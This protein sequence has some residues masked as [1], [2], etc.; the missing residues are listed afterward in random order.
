LDDSRLYAW[1]RRLGVDLRPDELRTALFLL[2]YFF[3]ITF[4]FY[5]VKT[6]KES[7]QI[8]VNERWWGYFDLG[9]A[10]LIGFVVAINTRLLNR[11]P[12]RK[13]SLLTL[14]FSAGCLVLFWFL[15]GLADWRKF[16]I[17]ALLVFAKDYWYLFV[18]AFS[19]WSDIFIAMSI[20]QFWIAV[21]DVLHP[22]QARRLVGFL[23]TGGLLG[24]IGGALVSRGLSGVWPPYRLLLICPAVLA[25]TILVV[26]L[27][28]GERDRVRG[29]TEADPVR[30]GTGVGYLESLRTVRSHRYLLLISGVLA[31][32]VIVGQLINYQFKFVVKAQPWNASGRT[33]F[34]ATFF[35]GILVL[36]L[37]FHLFTTGRL[38]KR[39]GI[40]LALLVAPLVLLLGTVPIFALTAAAA[41]TAVTAAG[42]RLWA[43]GLRGA[44]RSFDI[45]INQ[46]VRELL[47]IP[48]P[49]EIKY[50]A[51]VFID[52]FVNKFALGFG[53]VIYWVLYRAA[54]F[55][56]R[57][58]DARV[59]MLGF[60]VIAFA[61]VWVGLIWV[62][63]A[64]YKEA[65]N[66][67]LARI[68]Q[69]GQKV[70][71]QHVDL[72]LTRLIMNTIES[73]ERS[74]TLYAMNLFELV[75]KEKL[76][77]ELREAIGLKEDEVKARSMDA[78]LDVG[79]ETFFQSIEEAITDQDLE[80][81]VK[82]VMALPVYQ[83]LMERRI[84]DFVGKEG[85]SEVVRM[86]SAQ[87]LGRMALTPGVV[88]SIGRLLQD[89][90]ADVLNYA[91]GSAAVH[92]R[93]EHV[94]LIIPLLGNPSTQ[95]LAQE[96]LAAYGP[97]IED[98]LKK[99]LQHAGE[100][101]EVR[102][103]IPEVLGRYGDQKAADTLVTELM[104]GN[105]LL[106][107]DIIEAL[108]EIRSNHPQVHY[109]KK[110]VTA[111]VL[112]LIQRNAEEYLAASAK[113]AAGVTEGPGPDRKAAI[114]L[115]TKLIFDLL[116]LIAPPEEVVKAYQ[117]IHKGTKRSV[118]YS[119]E[120]LDNILDRELKV[121]LFP[122]VEDLTPDERC[123]RLRKLAR[124][125]GARGA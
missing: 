55:A 71:R 100:R 3:L 75:Q 5:V 21:N 73:R 15:F 82:E 7:Y 57:S 40:R 108:Y 101:P 122:L 17:P 10:I 45:T 81:I 125:R 24:G 54:S 64:D 59:R 103:A 18:F 39:F 94:P 25:L 72:D 23:V 83:E 105:A 86:E 91:L 117:N 76:T 42:G 2:L 44:D 78:L 20:T 121:H 14:G 116:T 97:R 68:W 30:A 43:M 98:V 87:V 31:S 102:K 124:G 90:S 4:S 111:A 89:P 114:D 41:A 49:A 19:F 60:F 118:D 1:L 119:L 95:Q 107:R 74:S 12:R 53:A 80:T 38:L 65:V 61:L 51:K 11:L 62:I 6:V 113:D 112:G 70:V 88:R 9:T 37:F 106:E 115:R 85:A 66:K 16:F 104:E 63:Y 8:S 96:T 13:Y 32:A 35:L 22:H 28:Q 50:K 46:S 52:M 56:E 47:Y 67:E 92:V 26:N 77:E 110:K 79:G 120:L 69:D 29:G 123:R 34:L 99:H 93:R 58:T 33:S 84:G 109:R 27:V 48:I 36:S